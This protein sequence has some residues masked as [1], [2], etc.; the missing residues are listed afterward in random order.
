MKRKGV[1]NV[2]QMP[3]MH[4]KFYIIDEFAELA[5]RG[6]VGQIIQSLA[7]LGC[8]AGI[9]LIIETRRAS[10]KV[11]N[12]EP[13]STN[14]IWKHT[15]RRGSSRG[16]ITPEGRALKESY[17]LQ[18]RSQYRGAPITG[19]LRVSPP[20]TSGRSAPGHRQLQQNRAR[21]LLRLRMGGRFADRGAESD[22]GL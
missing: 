13:R 19:A 17:E 4:Y 5:M 20:S 18:A 2:T 22:E 14:H 21:C 6:E 3:D 1:K 8:A 10:T 11:I 15:C 7:Q 12:G 9:Y 16:Y